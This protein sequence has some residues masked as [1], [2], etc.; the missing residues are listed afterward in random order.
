MRE[1]WSEL[2]RVRIGRMGMSVSGEAVGLIDPLPNRVLQGIGA[3]LEDV[4]L[5]KEQ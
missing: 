4:P 5:L 3:T 1:G 2:V